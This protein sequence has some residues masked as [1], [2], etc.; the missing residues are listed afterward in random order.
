MKTMYS[1]EWFE[2]FAATVPNEIIEHEVQALAHLL[3][4]GSH[5]R[6]VDVG[7]GTGRIA[8]PLASRGYCVTGIDIN[9]DALRIAKACKPA[10]IE[11][12][13]LDQQH[14]GRMPWSFDAALCMW[15]S[16]GFA[17]RE[18]DRETLAGIAA[19]IRPG[20]RA[21]FDMYHPEWLK[22]NQRAGEPDRGAVSVRR[23]MEG[24]RCCH[25]I[26]YDNG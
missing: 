20:G 4:L 3:P 8:A 13:A 21:V 22:Q 17:G 24:T 12:V 11:L 14:I 2:T 5:P 1:P 7:C 15:N 18:G 25:E 10:P 26:H 16:I 19:V 9:L 6:V 23:W